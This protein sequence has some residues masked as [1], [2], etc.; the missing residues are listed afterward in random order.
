METVFDT[1]AYAERLKAAGV[2]AAQANAHAE[3][4]R[5]ALN[6]GVA[7]KADIRE[8][9][10]EIERGVNRLLVAIIAVGGLVVAALKL[11]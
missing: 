1:L 5:V 2:S 4:L 11:L 6:Q 7:T 9:R 3:A 8:L 10:M